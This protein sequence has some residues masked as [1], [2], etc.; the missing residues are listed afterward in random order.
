[1]YIMRQIDGREMS[2]VGTPGSVNA[3]NKMHA[4]IRI[5]VECGI[6]GLKRKRRSVNERI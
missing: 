4:G 5:S 6:G 3:F 1:M 2:S